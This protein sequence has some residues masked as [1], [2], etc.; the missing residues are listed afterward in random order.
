MLVW[1]DVVFIP[2]VFSVQAWYL[3]TDDS[4]LNLWEVLG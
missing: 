1:G 3:L 4:M 2:F